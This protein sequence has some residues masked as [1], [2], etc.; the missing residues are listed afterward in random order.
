[1]TVPYEYTKTPVDTPALKYEIE[2]ST[3]IT[4]VLVGVNLKAP[5]GT[6]NLIIVFESALSPTEETELNTIVTNHTATPLNDYELWCFNCHEL[7]PVKAPSFPTEC[8]LCQSENINN[9]SGNNLGHSHDH[10]GMPNVINTETIRFNLTG[11]ISQRLGVDVA[12]IV[13]RTCTIT[14]IT[15]YR[16]EKGSSGSTIA[17]VNK[18]GVT[19][20]TTQANRPTVTVAGGDNQI[21]PH[22]DMDV[23]ALVQNDRIEVDIDQNEVGSPRDISVIVEV[24]Y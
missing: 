14:R 10:K 24:Q 22:T 21:D 19:V 2:Q 3:V 4:T 23:T 15:L 12:W 18:N 13:P 6:N 9:E 7:S 17:D 8:P 1:M 20:F 16:R 11:K 5:S